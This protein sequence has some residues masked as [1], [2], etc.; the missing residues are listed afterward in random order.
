[1]KKKLLTIIEIILM[2]IVLFSLYK[3]FIWN[4][5][6]KQNEDILKDLENAIIRPV[7]EE[8]GES[9]IVASP[10]EETKEEETYKP[11]TV[12]FDYLIN[13]NPDTVGYIIVNNTSISYPVV[14]GEDNDY[15]LTHNFYKQYNTAGWIFANYANNFD[16]TDKNITIYGHSRLNNSMFGDLKTLLNSSYYNYIDNHYITFM[17][18]DYSYKYKIFSIYKTTS[19]D[20]YYKNIF[21]NDEYST[22]LQNIINKSTYI[23]NEEVT[24]D[25]TILTLSTCDYNSDYRVVVHARKVK[26]L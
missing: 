5:E 17:T 24:I 25:D 9:T 21:K 4:K 22:F 12:D 20:N 15:Y 11:F 23:F 19:N 7:E 6:N 3:L 18:K 13:K 26:D 2:I 14:R 10:S 16:G 8:K 1:M